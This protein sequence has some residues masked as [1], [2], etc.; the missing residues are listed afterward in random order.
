MK[1]KLFRPQSLGIVD[2]GKREGKSVTFRDG[3]CV[4]GRVLQVKVELS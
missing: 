4:F 2:F 1:E 3:F